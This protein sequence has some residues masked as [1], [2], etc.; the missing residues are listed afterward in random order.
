MTEESQALL[1]KLAKMREQVKED[2]K[3]SE[4]IL[5][6]VDDIEKAITEGRVTKEI[7]KMIN[8]AF[9]DHIRVPSTGKPIKLPNKCW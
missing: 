2:M 3:T 5:G 8:D 7:L 6:L 9:N 4:R 1:A